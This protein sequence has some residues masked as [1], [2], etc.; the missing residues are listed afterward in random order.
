MEFEIIIHGKIITQ[1]K[2]NVKKLFDQILSETNSDFE[3]DIYV[4]EFDNMI[5]NLKEN[6]TKD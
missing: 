1:N 2:D 5:T 6:A 4:Y 3:G